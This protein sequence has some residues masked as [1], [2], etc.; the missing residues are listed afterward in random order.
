MADNYLERRMEDLKSGRLGVRNSVPGIKPGSRRVVAARG[1]SGEVRDKVFEFRRLGCRVAVF[2]SDEEAGKKMA[3]ENGVRFH[4]LDLYDEEALK[5]AT[6]DLLSSWRGVDII[7]GKKDE[8]SRIGRMVR[9]WK[10]SL[11]I[12]DKSET[13]FVIL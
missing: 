11:P 10:E 6:Y 8:C 12:P 3:Y 7:M 5:K 13:K 4:N 9:E 1:T 2:D